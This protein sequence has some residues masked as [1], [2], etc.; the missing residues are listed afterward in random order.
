GTARSSSTAALRSPRG[1]QTTTPRRAC[2]TSGD[3]DRLTRATAPHR[4][5]LLPER[6]VRDRLQRLVQ[7]LQLLRQPQEVV[8]VVCAPVQPGE[9]VADA[10]E[11]LEQDVEP[12]VREIVALHAFTLDRAA[13]RA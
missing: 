7:R 12:A 9:L 11:P 10:I 5:R 1:T 3:A 8:V 2:S 4:R 13:A 6:G